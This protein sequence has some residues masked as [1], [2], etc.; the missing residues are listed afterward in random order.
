MKKCAVF[1]GSRAG[2]HPEYI[3]AAKKLGEEMAERDIEL[4]YGG[5]SVGIMATVADAVLENGG[6]ATGVLPHFLGDREIAHKKLTELHMVETMS[7]RKQLIAKLSDGF[8][9]LPGGIGTMEEYFEML[10]LG[11]LGQH[12]GKSGL[13]NVNGYYKPLISFFDHM[14]EQG[15]VDEKTREGMIIEE[16]PSALL[17][18]IFPE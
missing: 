1:C 12:T 18:I 13:L 2:N 8:I 7:E 6:Q 14:K 15:F 10:T 17:D 11:Y 4:V 16:D 9:S 5:A 3:K